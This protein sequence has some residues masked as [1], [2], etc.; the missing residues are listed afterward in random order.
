ME[1]QKKETD[2]LLLF[3]LYVWLE[4][5][6]WLKKLNSSPSMTEYGKLE[7]LEQSELICKATNHGKR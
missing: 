7:W 4:P 3:E 5:R 2:F 1:L 6:K